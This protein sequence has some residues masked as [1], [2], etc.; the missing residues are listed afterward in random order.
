MDDS[1]INSP[2]LENGTTSNVAEVAEQAAPATEAVESSEPKSLRDAVIKAFE[3][4]EGTKEQPSTLPEAEPVKAEPAKE[5]DPITGREL[6]PIRAPSSMT[7]L[8][9]EK[10]SNVPRE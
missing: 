8:L 6:E 5:I 4:N 3:K 10:W 2:E 1:N 9:R 7:P